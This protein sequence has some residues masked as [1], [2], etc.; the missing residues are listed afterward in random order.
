[1]SPLLEGKEE[2]RISRDRDRD[3][4]RNVPGVAEVSRRERQEALPVVVV[5]AEV[6]GVEQDVNAVHSRVIVVVVVSLFI[7][8]SKRETPSGSFT[9]SICNIHRR[10]FV[11]SQGQSLCMSS[12]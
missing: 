9:P 10:P 6:E 1:M 2:E 5:D 8:L 3:R 11:L 12:S 7:S 4:D